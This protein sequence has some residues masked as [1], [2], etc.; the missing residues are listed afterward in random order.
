MR[1]GKLKS[2][3]ALSSAL[4]CGLTCLGGVS[5]ISSCSST[6]EG[7]LYID[8]EPSQT[9]YAVGDTF[10]LKGLSVYGKKVV[11]GYLSNTDSVL[12]EDYSTSI[13]EGSVLETEGEFDVTV[14]RNGYGST[15]FK[16]YVG[17]VKVNK[18]V[19]RQLPRKLSYKVGDKFKTD[20]LSLAIA[21]YQGGKEIGSGVTLVNDQYSLS[22]K[23]GEK[24]NTE[25]S[26][27]VE[28]Y[29]EGYQSVYFTIS[30]LTENTSLSN[31]MSTLVNSHNYEL[32][33][34][35]TV[36]TTV[37][38]YGFHYKEI[39]NSNYFNKITY[40]KS[41]ADE[42][43]EDRG[44]SEESNI[45]YVNYD[46][47][48]YQVDLT[49]QDSEGNPKPGKVLSGETKW[50]KADLVTNLEAFKNVDIP[51]TTKNGKFIV[52]VVLD[53]DEVEANIGQTNESWTTSIANN[54]FAAAFLTVCGWSDSLISILTTIEIETDGETYLNLKGN[55]GGYGYTTLNVSSIGHASSDV[56]DI[57]MNNTSRTFD[58]TVD[59]CVKTP[60]LLEL[61]T[62]KL[63]NYTIT[64]SGSLNDGTTFTSY[65]IYF[66][67]N[68]I[69]FEP[70]SYYR[71][72]YYQ[73]YK[74]I[75]YSS[76]YFAVNT[77][78]DKLLELFG[79]DA[80]V[81]GE[82]G[83]REVYTEDGTGVYSI[84]ATPSYD[85]TLNTFSDTIEFD[86]KHIDL[87]SYTDSETK[88]KV[89]VDPKDFTQYEYSSMKADDNDSSLSYN[90]M[91]EE[92]GCLLDTSLTPNY[93]NTWFLETR[94][95]T[96]EA[97]FIVSYD[98]NALKVLGQ[99]LLGSEYSKYSSQFNCAV[100]SPTYEI[101]ENTKE[102]TNIT[103]LELWCLNMNTYRGYA[104][105]FGSI[106]DTSLPEMVTTALS[107]N[108]ITL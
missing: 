8:S 63:H 48:V 21:T 74:A 54:P 33:I 78:N 3:L 84:Y 72:L 103:N 50:Y 16:I 83:T 49:K 45:A 95:S 35:N 100:I 57:Y 53:R 96:D 62:D 36:A 51:T 91:F 30:V 108:G 86:S 5:L 2:V 55:L 104:S 106:N 25:G 7:Y 97:P 52:E 77:P 42:A 19:I 47:G 40:K 93:A 11:N 59:E 58:T 41:S 13:K 15:S 101:D 88:K 66:G 17:D 46:K 56:L 69:W 102:I 43:E 92:I 38:E 24:L 14:S 22:I 34:Y 61:F 75:P 44:L 23:N 10:S 37:N 68:F 18:L 85:K 12:I 79:K 94:L 65:N 39:V 98:P 29:K 73:M 32:E 70:S 6:S 105:K 27:L 67:D 20:G 80:T 90:F 60:K 28:C 99:A 9:T 71:S 31:I 26:Y 89:A 4:L 64:L 107:N 82:T 87:V 76:G 81:E 1:K